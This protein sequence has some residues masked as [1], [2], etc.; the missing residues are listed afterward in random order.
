MVTL[1]VFIDRLK[2]L[3]YQA[4]KIGT[5]ILFKRSSE[6]VKKNNAE[7]IKGLNTQ[8]KIIQRGY[9]PA[10]GKRRRKA[11]LQTSFVDLYFTGKFQESSKGVKAV[12]GLDIDSGVDYEKYLRKNYE[13]IRGLNKQQAD[14]EAE[15]IAKLLAVE[16]KKYLVK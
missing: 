16:L 13:D 4:K 2:G 15:K 6:I 5:E 9:S 3:E 1:E 12:E 11:G 10:Y 7:L 8:G 14:E